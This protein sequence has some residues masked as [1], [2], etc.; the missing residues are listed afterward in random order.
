[1]SDFMV[2]N[3]TIKH[4][5]Q[6]TLGTSWYPNLDFAL[7]KKPVKWIEGNSSAVNVKMAEPDRFKDIKRLPGSEV[8]EFKA[9]NLSLKKNEGQINFNWEQLNLEE[10]Q[11]VEQDGDDSTEFF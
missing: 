5:V 4:S 2:A 9:A 8:T 10:N 1:M 7:K 6:L 11:G 3:E